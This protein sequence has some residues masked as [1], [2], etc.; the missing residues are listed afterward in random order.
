MLVSHN[1][2]CF[3]YSMSMSRGVNKK[4]PKIVP[5]IPPP[6]HVFPRFVRSF[7]RNTLWTFFCSDL[8]DYCK[9]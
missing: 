1:F 9:K 5:P 4:A 6:N 8:T 2:I 7:T 3:G